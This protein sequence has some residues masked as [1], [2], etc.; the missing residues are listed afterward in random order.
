[1]T[2]PIA[3][4]DPEGD[5]ASFVSQGFTPTEAGGIWT[6]GSSTFVDYTNPQAVEY[7][8]SNADN[9]NVIIGNDVTQSG[10]AITLG[11]PI[12]ANKI[13][14][15][16]M[17]PITVTCRFP[18]TA[19]GTRSRSTAAFRSPI[20][21]PPALLRH[22]PLMVCADYPRHTIEAQDVPSRAEH[23]P[24]REPSPRSMILFLE[25]HPSLPRPAPDFYRLNPVGVRSADSSS[26]RQDRT[27]WRGPI[28][29]ASVR[30]LLSIAAAFSSASTEPRAIP[31]PSAP[32]MASSVPPTARAAARRTMSPSPVTSARQ[33][34]RSPR[35]AA[36]T[37]RSMATSPPAP[38]PTR[39]STPSAAASPP[40]MAP[41]PSRQVN[42]TGGTLKPS[43][44]AAIGYRARS[45]LTGG[46]PRHFRVHHLCQQRQHRH[47]R[48][49]GQH[50][51]FYA[52]HRRYHPLRRHQR[53]WQLSPR[54]HER[55][56]ALQCQ[57]RRQL[58]QP[59]YRRHDTARHQRIR[60][61]EPPRRA[62]I[63]GR[64][65]HR[66]RGRRHR[67]RHPDR[68]HHWFIRPA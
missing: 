27:S 37:P 57:H 68:H 18:T 65:N 22:G 43:S 13:T 33:A 53:Q 62:W 39:P 54:R 11:S 60:R 24:S 52:E 6:D 8:W 28:R 66:H 38:S 42:V 64:C 55:R 29:S 67:E 41:T 59:R 47:Q 44:Q 40:L 58:P 31:S 17:P 34:I 49:Y 16:A 4:W 21:P 46:I 23:Q 10:A 20:R 2:A 7:T 63:R 48:L 61:W 30:R 50:L 45:S 12:V 5:G 3:Q 56:H 14:F 9:K 35:S 51:T 19:A 25:S 1:M 15:S 26:T 36:V 32:A